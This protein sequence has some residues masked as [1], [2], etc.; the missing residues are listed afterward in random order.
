MAVRICVYPPEFGSGPKRS[1]IR[2]SPVL[3][4]P[5]L[6]FLQEFAVYQ[7]LEVWFGL[8][9]HNFKYGN[10]VFGRY[11]KSEM[12]LG[13]PG[14]IFAFLHAEVDHVFYT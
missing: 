13:T 6:Q 9:W 14:C 4:F 7:L 3:R 10:A 1:F 11:L 12:V 2:V 5:N 8:M